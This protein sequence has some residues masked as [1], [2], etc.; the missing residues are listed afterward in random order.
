MIIQES[1]SD[2]LLLPTYWACRGLEVSRSGYY[3]WLR[4]PGEEASQN[5]VEMDLMNQIQNIALEFPGYGYRRVTMELRNRGYLANHKHVLR[6]MR[7]DNLLCLKKKFKPVTTISDHGLPIYSNLLKEV[8]ITGPNQV[9]ASDITYVQLSHEWIYLAVVLDLFSRKC[10]GWDL[11]RR[12]DAEI[13]MNALIMA[14]KTRWTESIDGLIH[15]SDQGIQYAS[16][17]YKD[18]LKEH[19]IQISMSR[20]GNP[21]DNAFVESFIKTLKSEEVYLNEYATFQEA[22]ENICHFIE[23]VYNKKRLHSALGYRSPEQ[24]EMEVGLNSIA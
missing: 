11:N 8:E 9:W 23:E 1:L 16:N 19:N 12:M 3:K 17:K 2:G 18:C 7:E 21:Y 14:L 10:I 13:A 24:F 20:R 15:H 4:R 22:L 5:I 6:I